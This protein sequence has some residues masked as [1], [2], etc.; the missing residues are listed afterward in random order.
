MELPED[1]PRAHLPLA[2]AFE[3]LD[4]AFQ[5]YEDGMTA[6]SIPLAL[7]PAWRT[8]VK[9]RHDPDSPL[10]PSAMGPGSVRAFRDHLFALMTTVPDAAT[11]AAAPTLDRWC[12]IRSRGDCLLI[13]RVN[14]HPLLRE[15]ARAT[16]SP[17]FRIAAAD[18][19]A[20]TWSRIYRLLA[21][22]PSF[23]LDLQ[24]DDRLPPCTE[25]VWEMMPASSH[26]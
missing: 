16:T 10:G 8:F 21:P 15:N 23:F 13:G 17:L 24:R 19:W 11:A 5:L 22:D 1:I 14:G 9:A 2:E 7:Q 25:I 20:R 4:E 26:H 12:V 18:G 3:D 6:R